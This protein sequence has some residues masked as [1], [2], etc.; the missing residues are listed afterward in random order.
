MC[1]ILVLENHKN[2][3]AQKIDNLDKWIIEIDCNWKRV[4]FIILNVQNTYIKYFK[5]ANKTDKQ[6][7]L[8]WIQTLKLK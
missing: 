5:Q 7:N 6:N 1:S 3:V 2:F 8:I 4:L